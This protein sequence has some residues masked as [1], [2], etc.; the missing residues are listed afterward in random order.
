MGQCDACSHVSDLDNTHRLASYIFKNPPE[1]K[2]SIK[3]P[4]I[5]NPDDIKK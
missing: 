3:N 1:N 2:A 4:D 5:N